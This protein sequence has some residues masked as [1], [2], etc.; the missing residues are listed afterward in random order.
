VAYPMYAQ[1]PAPKSRPTTVRVS[2]YL[3]YVTAAISVI[4][5]V[6]AL[7]QIG[8][9]NSVYK[10]VYAGTA[11]Q[12][13]EAAAGIGAVIGAV[14]NIAFAAGIVIL[15]HFNNKGRQGSRITTWVLAGISACCTAAGAAAN[16]LT[17][18]ITRSMG[19]TSSAGMPSPAE[20]QRR[21][22]D[23]LPSWYTPVTV[24]LAVI[25]ALAAVGAIILLALP[26]SNEYFR[27]TVPVF[28]PSVP[29]PQYGGQ[30]PYPGGQPP[31]PPY[32][33]QPGSPGGSDPGQ[34]GSSYPGQPGSSYPGQ[35]GSSYPRQPGSPGGQA[36]HTGSIPPTDPWGPPRDNDN[37][38]DRPPTDPPART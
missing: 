4:S 15:A 2:S 18:T 9:M 22:H 14:F 6:I 16:G 26:A 3:L 30:P 32:P 24:T 38:P 11:A 25:S 17:T 33:G 19:N 21:L 37:G 35:P 8:T 28:D 5:A 23:A 29:Y 1:P 36:P 20:V 27:K 7:S 31:Y 10:D 12:G 13:S 34:P